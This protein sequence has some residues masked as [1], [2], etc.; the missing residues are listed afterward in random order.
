LE[1][2]PPVVLDSSATGIITDLQRQVS[3]LQ[4]KSDSD[5][6]KIDALQKVNENLRYG[7]RS[8]QDAIGS[9]VRDI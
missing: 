3:D 1:D 9:Y 6:Y 8:I 2:N 5:E 4:A 7:L